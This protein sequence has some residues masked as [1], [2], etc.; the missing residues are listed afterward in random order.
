M[1]NLYQR[2]KASNSVGTR[3]I[4]P[5]VARRAERY[6]ALG[7]SMGEFRGTSLNS[8]EPS[9]VYMQSMG[10]LAGAPGGRDDAL[11]LHG[12]GVSEEERAN[13]LQ[14]LKWK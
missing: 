4:K 7:K 13:Q 8:R 14:A 12:S 5:R 11:N 1:S 2:Q 9:S 10:S 3:L 6:D